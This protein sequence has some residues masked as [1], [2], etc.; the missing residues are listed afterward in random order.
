MHKRI[1]LSEEVRE[2]LAESRP[3][4]A[5]ESTIISHGMP[6][7]ENLESALTSERIIRENGAVPATVAVIGGKVRVGLSHDELTYMGEQSGIRKASRC[8]LP[9]I[10]A[11]GRDGATTVATTMLAAER[12]GI[13]VFATGGIGGAHRQAQ[14][15]FDV[16]ADLLEL[17][18]SSV[19]VVC[20]G[21]KSILDIGLTLE[22]L[23]THGVPVIGYRTDAFPA[24]YLRDSGYP[25][26]D[27]VDDMTVLAEALR[28][29]WELALTG[30]LVIANPIP[31]EHEMEPELIN[32]C[33][34][35][36]VAEADRRGIRGKDVTPFVL[37]RLHEVTEGASVA[38]NKAL[39]YNNA[40]VAAE[41]AVAYAQLSS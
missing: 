24:F 34:A 9:V 37:A 14:H 38:A 29:K 15:T 5:L 40:R 36:A 6:F 17:G 13:A 23:E 3:L 8:D 19:A 33:I 20:A 21:A 4:V 11:T 30:G 27:R 1:H 25:V 10:L 18:R 2:A 26:D 16:S 41:L 12:A 31:A 32:G 28:L 39:V 7:P 22:V 35:E